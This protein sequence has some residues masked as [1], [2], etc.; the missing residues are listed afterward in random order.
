MAVGVGV[1]VGVAELARQLIPVV[2]AL[3]R[4]G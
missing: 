3:V 2:L 1:G 4:E